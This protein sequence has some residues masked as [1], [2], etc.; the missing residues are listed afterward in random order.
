MVVLVGAFD[1]RTGDPLVGVMTQPFWKRCPATALWQGRQA[2]GMCAA[3]KRAFSITPPLKLKVGTAGRKLVV[4]SRSEDEAIKQLL[5]QLGFEVVHAA[6]AGY[7]ALCV[8]DSLA[9]V[10]VLSKGSTY[11]WDTCGP[12]AILR[13]M[14]GD[15]V[16][17]SKALKSG[18]VTEE[19]ALKYSVLAGPAEDHSDKC[20]SGGVLAF[21]CHATAQSICDRSTLKGKD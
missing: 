4:I 5:P 20:N 13:A 8:V 15:M 17:W 1:R 11:Q 21:R 7:K 2:W 9:D 10:Y 6:G 12:Q 14:G 19:E 3:G 16:D 18:R